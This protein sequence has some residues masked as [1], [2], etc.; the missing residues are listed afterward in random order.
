MNVEISLLIN[1]VNPALLLQAA[2]DRAPGVELCRANGTVDVEGCLRILRAPDE[3]LPG[4]EIIDCMI[5]ERGQ[6]DDQ[7]PM[8]YTYCDRCGN[9]LE[10]GQIGLCDIC[11]EEARDDTV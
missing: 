3:P 7:D 10:S 9:R 2:R 5:E 6:P 1:V 4:C 8:G 11:Q